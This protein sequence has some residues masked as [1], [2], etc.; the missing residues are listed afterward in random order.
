MRKADDL[1]RWL[2]KTKCLEYYKNNPEQLTIFLDSGNVAARRGATRSFEYRYTLTIAFENF[3]G[4]MDTI[5]VPLL[6]WIERN[7]PDL[8]QRADDQP[9]QFEGEILDSQSVYLVVKIDISEAVI[10][11][12]KPGG[13]YNT[14]PPAPAAQSWPDGINAPFRQGYGF[15]ELLAGAED[16][17]PAP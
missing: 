1:R 16:G 12:A 2:T 3:C 8:L 5:M 9:I 15:A 7:Q 4:D 10:V 13:G 17:T 14:A 6:A 11:T